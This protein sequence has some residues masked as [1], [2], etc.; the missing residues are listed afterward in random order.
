MLIYLI[1]YEKKEESYFVQPVLMHSG[2][3]SFSGLPRDWFLSH[4]EMLGTC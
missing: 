4:G 1:S 2:G 3:E